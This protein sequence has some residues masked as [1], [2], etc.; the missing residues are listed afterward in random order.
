VAAFAATAPAARLA[1]ETQLEVRA[2]PERPEARTLR[3][4][5]GAIHLTLEEMI[6]LALE[7]NLGLVGQRIG[8]LR[9]DLGLRSAATLYDLSLTGSLSTS[10]ATA[11]ILEGV[12]G[13]ALSSNA[14]AGSLG[15]SRLLPSGAVASVDWSASRAA[16]T[17]SSASWGAGLGLNLSQPLLAGR[18][19]RLTELGLELTR[20]GDAS[21]AESFEL[22]V[23]SVVG[24]AIATY[25][26]LVGAAEQ[27]RVSEQGLEAGRGL[28]EQSRLKVEGGLIPPLELV[29]SEFGLSTREEEVIRARSSLDDAADA[30]RRLLSVTDRALWGLPIATDTAPDE[31]DLDVDLD[32]AVETALVERPEL[33]QQRLALR[34][35]ELSAWA[36]RRALEPRLDLN[37]AYGRSGIGGT[38]SEVDPETGDVTATLESGFVDAQRQ[39]LDRDFANWSVGLVVAYPL[40]NRAA[41]IALTQA[42]LDLEGARVDL[43]SAEVE[44]VADVHQAARLLASARLSLDSARRS[45]AL[46]EKNLEAEQL[47][48]ENGRSTSFRVVDVQTDLNAAR[49]RE[50]TALIAYL[51]A[52]SDFHRSVGRLL[53]EVGVTIAGP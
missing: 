1:A 22:A 44:V 45:T 2:R 10:E 36:A 40:G 50:V 38:V 19:R 12:D 4:E 31:R 3:V 11:P 15:L 46:S 30:V 7:R 43:E 37:V 17:G 14:Q 6:E 13:P 47:R 8:R 33:R 35:A 21:S 23:T 18:G 51:R 32:A 27:L 16:S 24:Q 52:Q 5:D 28:Y 9:T 53:D 39:L 20:I 49:S 48:Y 34:S 29:Q 41:K 26:N 25:W 42:E